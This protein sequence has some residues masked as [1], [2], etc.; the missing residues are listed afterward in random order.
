[1]LSDEQLESKLLELVPPNGGVK[2][3][4]TLRDEWSG[5]AT[6]NHCN[7]TVSDYW[8]IRQRLLDD[9]RL[10][11]GRGKGGS[12][13]RAP[14]QAVQTSTT[15]QQQIEPNAESRENDYYEQ[16]K[17]TIERSWAV[18]ELGL[19]ADSFV[20][21]VSAH[22]GRAYTGGKWSRPDITLVAVRRFDYLGPQT[23]VTTFEVKLY[24][25]LDVHGAFEAAAHT[26]RAH[27]AYLLGQV[28]AD[29]EKDY[30]ES[31][32]FERLTSECLR[33]GVGLATFGDEKDAATWEVHVRPRAHTPD[34]A[35]LDAWI[36]QCFKG[37]SAKLKALVSGAF[38][39]RPGGGQ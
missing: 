28:P 8:R 18:S 21:C 17:N 37:D 39:A 24:S 2:G 9:G 16:T 36:H 11:L 31:E 5:W 3:N 34:P 38:G 29:R 35:E 32:S 6:E 30:F 15:A 1:M 22:Q 20:V 14:D 12:V 27:R 26:A 23:D 7:V 25:D 33:F 10:E 19:P 13:R 4:V